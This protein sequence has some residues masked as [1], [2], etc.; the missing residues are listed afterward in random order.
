M[1]KKVFLF[2]FLFGVL[3]GNLM[4]SLFSCTKVHSSSVRHIPAA[5]SLGM[6]CGMLRC[7]KGFRSCSVLECRVAMTLW[8]HQIGWNPSSS[9]CQLWWHRWCP[10]ASLLIHQRRVTTQRERAQQ[11]NNVVGAPANTAH[12]MSRRGRYPLCWRYGSFC[13]SPVKLV[14]F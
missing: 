2:V 8:S 6:E 9:P 12:T 10:W 3:W 5:G 13:E 11:M 14:G 1:V 7:L 4:R